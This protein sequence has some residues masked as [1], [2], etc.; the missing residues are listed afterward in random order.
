VLA[1]IPHVACERVGGEARRGSLPLV[2]S[3]APQYQ[4]PDR[5][6]ESTKRFFNTHPLGTYATNGVRYKRRSKV[7]RAAPSR[8]QA[9][10]P[11][12][13]RT[14]PA[15]TQA[16]PGKSGRAAHP[17]SDPVKMGLGR[18]AA[19]AVER[20][21]RPHAAPLAST[22]LVAP[23]TKSRHAM[24]CALLRPPLGVESQESRRRAAVDTSCRA[25]GARRGAPTL[26][27]IF[28]RLLFGC[29]SHKRSDGDVSLA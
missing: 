13:L 21:E 26:L 14:K 7:Y 4:S 11:P 5:G 29:Q 10:P 22:P 25:R 16:E 18:E 24:G 6:A 28:L 12:L 2:G 3:G 9:T 19:G 1:D 8:G 15:A 20:R 27:P 23:K 17:L